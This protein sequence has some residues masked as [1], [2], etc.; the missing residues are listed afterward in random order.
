[1][2]ILV[3]IDDLLVEPPNVFERHVP[4]K[5]RDRAPRIEKLKGAQV[6][7]AR[8]QTDAEHRTRRDGGTT[9]IG[10][11]ARAETASLRADARGLPQ[12]RC[13]REGHERERD[14]RFAVPSDAPRHPTVGSSAR[15]R[16]VRSASSCGK[17]TTTGTS[18]SG[19]VCT[20]RGSSLSRKPG[21]GPP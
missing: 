21:I 20:S 19:S 3:S 11:R 8:G 5:Y 9:E 6:L 12:G 7:S 2:L 17:R 15:W 13:A 16:I 4:A 10:A 14:V 1:D 18:T